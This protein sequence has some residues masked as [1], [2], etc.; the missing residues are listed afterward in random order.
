MSYDVVISPRAQQEQTD[1]YSF[2][3]D[4]QEGLGERFFKS[5]QTCFDKIAENPRYYSLISTSDTLRDTKLKDFPFVVIYIIGDNAVVTI[6][7]R[8]TSR[9]PYF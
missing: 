1:A 9:Q 4:L 7:V 5:L 6:S 3:E 2:Y 8:H